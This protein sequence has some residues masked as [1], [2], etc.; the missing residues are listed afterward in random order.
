MA[1]IGIIGSA[2]RMGQAIRAEV[3]AQ[4][5]T[6]AGGVDRDAGDVAALAAALTRIVTDADLRRRIATA[7]LEECR[8][9]YSWHAVGRQIMEVYARVRHE[10]PATDFPE[11]LPDDPTCRFRAEPHLL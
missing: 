3:E 4:G 11:D 5:L 2:G 9:V 6:F 7:G 1:R 8:R 10:Q